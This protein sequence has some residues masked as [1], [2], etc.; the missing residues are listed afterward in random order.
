MRG[1]KY[2]WI[3]GFAVLLSGCLGKIPQGQSYEL[4]ANAEV[5]QQTL[6]KNISKKRMLE[7]EIIVAPKIA[8]KKI[9][10]KKDA[11]TIAYFAKN[12]WIEPFSEILNALSQKV[13]W[14]YGIWKSDD[15]GNVE[16]IKINVLD[17]YFDT[18]KESVFVQLLVES[19]ES[20]VLI[21]KEEAVESGGFVKIIYAFERALNLAFADV[22]LSI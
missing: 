13:A 16:Q 8:G 2:I 12:T 5:L 3:L 15:K 19:K 4:G 17:C 9:A 14:N 7:W 22:F 1:I 11:N 6:P 20:S 18:K 10:Y 21:V